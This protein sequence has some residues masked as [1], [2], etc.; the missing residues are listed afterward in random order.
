MSFNFNYTPSRIYFDINVTNIDSNA[1][2]NPEL[3]FTE[4]RL[5]P[6]VANP[7]DYFMS[8]V[9]FALDTPS[10]PVFFPTIQPSQSDVNLT[11]Y[12][13]TMTYNGTTVQTY[14]QFVPQDQSQSLPN[15]PINN[16]PKLQQYS[17]Y[18]Y[19]YD[20]EYVVQLVNT[21]LSNCFNSL[22]NQQSSLFT[23]TAPFLKWNNSAK[24]ATLYTDEGYFS[25]TLSTPIKLYFNNALFNLF[26]SFPSNFQS[27]SN[28]NGMNYLISCNSFGNAN[29]ETINNIP[30]LLCE[31]EYSTISVWSP[32]SSIVF[33]T[34][35][36]PI[37]SELI[38]AP[39]IYY[40]NVNYKSTINT[41]ISN[42]IT[43]FEASEMNYVPFLAYQ[44]NIYRYVE[45]YG[46][47]PLMTLDIRCFWKN[48][49]GQLIPFI[50]NSGSSASLK[51]MF[52]LKETQ[53]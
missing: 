46:N 1:S 44:P 48:K 28:S 49:V 23:A 18:Y 24:L 30:Y 39:N 41:G 35:S 50:L 51:V 33:T 6:I 11:I 7:S 22:V 52:A 32:V 8:I 19:V 42:V 2:K 16:T 36:M 27:S 4:T 38:C 31:Q 26:N 45:L 40:N 47:S 21:A 37:V 25:P 5:T 14:I 34:N 53:N 20:Y 43:D 17:P 29:T 13:V 15:E 9:R 10:L 12:S 3:Q